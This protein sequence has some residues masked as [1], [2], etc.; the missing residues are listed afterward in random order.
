MM[1][2]ASGSR[3]FDAG[4]LNQKLRNAEMIDIAIVTSSSSRMR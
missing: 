3:R 4:L 1:K 2:C